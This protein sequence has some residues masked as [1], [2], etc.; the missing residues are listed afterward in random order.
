MKK[1]QISDF[2]TF[3]PV[4]QG[5]HHGLEVRLQREKGSHENPRTGRLDMQH[6]GEGE[7]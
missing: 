3:F 5:E 7:P 2:A 1:L 6:E 4:R